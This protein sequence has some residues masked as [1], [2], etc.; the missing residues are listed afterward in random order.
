MYEEREQHK[1][2]K[3]NNYP[4]LSPEDKQNKKK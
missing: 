3:K 1:E 2:V 4:Y